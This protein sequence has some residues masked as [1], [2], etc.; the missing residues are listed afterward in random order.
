MESNVADMYEKV[1][2]TGASGRLGSNLVKRLTEDGVRVRSFIL[3]DDPAEQTL[4]GLD[5]E[6]AYGDLRDE[7]AV[8]KALD[9]VDGVVHCA[10]VMGGP[11]GDLTAHKFFDINVRG[12]FNVFQ[13]AADRA[14]KIRKIVYFSSTAAY[15]VHTQGP[16]IREDVELRPLN[17]YGLTKATNETMARIVQFQ[18]NIPV[19]IFRPNYIMACEEIL[20]F[21]RAATVIGALK[22]AVKDPR[23]TYYIADSEEPWKIV[24]EA[25]KSA[26]QRCVPRDPDGN[27]WV[28]H[29][30]D[31]RDAVQATLLALTRDE[32]NGQT[33]SVAGP[34]PA[35]W[36]E[37]VP[38]LCEKLGEEYVQV[39]VPVLWHFEFDLSRAKEL[40]GYQPEYP[41]ERMIDDA[42]R[43]RNGKDI[44]VIPPAIPH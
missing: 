27:P 25:V 32:A 21:G 19:V 26:R 8:E 7:S 31:V 4:S 12:T 2:V 17:L 13:A 16:V 5:T 1:L 41:P 38:Y 24:E 44:G 11:R 37:V 10:A 9:G 22:A 36:D 33:F 23:L 6:K 42:I 14:E 15:D 43:F 39:G 40:L 3:P 34:K 28:W 29:V 18:T 20:G 35:R 30:T